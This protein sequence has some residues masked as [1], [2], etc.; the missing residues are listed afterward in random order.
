MGGV[1]AVSGLP[2]ELARS[3]CSRGSA[4]Q[5]V[6]WENRFTHQDRAEEALT[7]RWQQSGRVR[8]N[9]LSDGGRGREGTRLTFFPCEAKLRAMDML[10]V[11][12]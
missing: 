12:E 5:D 4:L 10:G 11:V 1:V 9:E 8:R 6:H 3:S 7:D 2:S